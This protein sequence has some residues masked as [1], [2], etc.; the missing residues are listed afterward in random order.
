MVQLPNKS[1]VSTFVNRRAFFFVTKLAILLHRY[2]HWFTY[3][4][5][6][7][8]QKINDIFL[9]RNWY[10][11]WSSSHLNAKEVPKSSQVLDFKFL[12]KRVFQI[13]HFYFIITSKNYVV[14][15][16]DKNSYIPIWW[17]FEKHR[18]IRLS[19]TIPNFLNSWSETVNQ[20]LGDCFRSY[21]DFFNLHTWFFFSM[22]LNL[23]GISM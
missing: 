21:K 5:T 20:G 12:R 19:L 8:F 17:M 10:S 7:F 13:Y 16:D 2:V 15:V 18:M 23:E 9:L 6:S 4:H 1:P 22:S 14:H 3:E 11:T